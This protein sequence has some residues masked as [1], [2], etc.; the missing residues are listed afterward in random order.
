[1]KT[2]NLIGLMAV[3][4]ETGVPYW[5]IVYAHKKGAIPWP[6]RVV[7]TWAYGPDDVQR[8][9]RYFAGKPRN[10]DVA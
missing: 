7:D 5:R 4:R 3:A 1:M 10:R 9:T 8:I 2:E 6:A